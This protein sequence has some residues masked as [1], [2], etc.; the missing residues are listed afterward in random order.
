MPTEPSDAETVPPSRSERRVLARAVGVWWVQRL[1]EAARR[2]HA[3]GQAREDED[4]SR[5]AP[6]IR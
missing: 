5:T 1:L 2:R 3:S 6:A 4:L